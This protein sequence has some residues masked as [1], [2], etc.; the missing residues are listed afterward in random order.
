MDYVCRKSDEQSRIE[1]TNGNLIC[2]I[3]KAEKNEEVTLT[4]ILKIAE[5][6]QCNAGDMM[7]FIPDDSPCEQEDE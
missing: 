6:M 3:Y 7:D 5:V 4:V 2:Y 1:K